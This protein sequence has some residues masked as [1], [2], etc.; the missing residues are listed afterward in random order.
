MGCG[1]AKP[2]L[3]G[4]IAE[5]RVNPEKGLVNL[6]AAFIQVTTVDQQESVKAKVPQ[7][8]E[9]LPKAMQ[10]LSPNN[11][12][13]V[14]AACSVIE[15]CVKV[16]ND[17]SLSSG[18]VVIAAETMK[19]CQGRLVGLLKKSQEKAA[20]VFREDQLE[21]ET[22]SNVA[23]AIALATVALFMLEAHATDCKH[24]LNKSGGVAVALKAMQTETS[25]MTMK[26]MESLAL[27]LSLFADTPENIAALIAQGGSFALCP[28]VEAPK[29][30][31]VSEDMQSYCIT[32]LQACLAHGENLK[33]K[34]Q[35][36]Q[37]LD[38]GASAWKDSETSQ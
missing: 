18:Q 33:N 3:E 26:T 17:P 38:R 30:H 5:L 13:P 4:A 27:M 25:G 23:R 19:Q 35:I 9:S 8:F 15:S 12:R 6:Q 29:T 14:L 37:V 2:T 32:V 11:P 28:Y 34:I 24:S 22:S 10:G 36:Q 1:N 20:T 16:C 31:D 21:C 7:I